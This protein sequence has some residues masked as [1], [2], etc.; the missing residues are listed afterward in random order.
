MLNA[1]EQFAFLNLKIASQ[2]HNMD[3]QL[4]DFM[5]FGRQIYGYHNKFHHNLI[6]LTHHYIQLQLKL[7]QFLIPE[8]IY[9]PIQIK[10]TLNS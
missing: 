5:A 6:I 10:N 7:F 4:Y 1:M 2:I 3:C 8:K 9:I